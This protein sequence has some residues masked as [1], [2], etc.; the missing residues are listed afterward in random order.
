VAMFDLAIATD[1][2][3]LLLNDQAFTA[4]SATNILLGTSA[5]TAT[6]DMTQLT[7]GSGYTTGGSSITWNTV[8]GAATSNSNTIS[9]TNS[10]SSWSLVGLEIWNSGATTRYLWGTW[11]GNPVTVNTGNTF[12]VAAAG[13]VVT[14]Q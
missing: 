1:L 2:L 4:V 6:V 7:G 13:I 12:Q 3:A 14:L 9:W 10:G 8:S 11:T 5:P